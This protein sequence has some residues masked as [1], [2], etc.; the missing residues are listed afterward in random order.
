M[1]HSLDEADRQRLVGL[2]GSMTEPLPDPSPQL[3]ALLVAIA[4]LGDAEQV[5]VARWVR[6]YV[7]RWGQITA[8]AGRKIAHPDRHEKRP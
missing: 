1:L 4:E 8:A 5:R 7:T 2:F 3:R 6:R